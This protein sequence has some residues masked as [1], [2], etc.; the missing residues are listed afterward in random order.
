MTL[1]VCGNLQRLQRDFVGQGTIGMRRGFS[2][3]LGAV[4]FTTILS[5]QLVEPSDGRSTLLFAAAALVGFALLGG[6]VGRL[7]ERIQLTSIRTPLVHRLKGTSE[8]K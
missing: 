6:L 1:S 4:A 7:A 8:R 5:R 3:M 2:A